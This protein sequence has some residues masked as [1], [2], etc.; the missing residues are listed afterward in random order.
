MRKPRVGRALSLIAL[1]LG[2]ALLLAGTRWRQPVGMPEQ[3]S[4]GGCAGTAAL[5]LV[6][7]TRAMRGP[8]TLALDLPGP[9]LVEPTPCPPGRR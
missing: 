3:G 8:E 6:A 9:V 7:P 1:L 2:M 5:L 4:A